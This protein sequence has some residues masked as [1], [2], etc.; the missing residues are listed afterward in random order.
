MRASIICGRVALATELFPHSMAAPLILGTIG[1]CGGERVELL[2]PWQGI[3]GKASLASHTLRAQLPSEPR[4]ARTGGGMH[5]TSLR[6]HAERKSQKKM[7]VCRL[8]AYVQS[9]LERPLPVPT[10]CVGPPC[11]GKSTYDIIRYLGGLATGP[12]EVSVPSY[13]LRCVSGVLDL[14]Q[15]EDV[16]VGHVIQ[17]HTTVSCAVILPF[18]A[19]QQHMQS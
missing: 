5:I 11:T 2:H 6:V 17:Q 12:V 9:L 14:I 16:A 13:S 18:H 10:C 7:Y 1:A 19:E 15:H 3:L 8:P 4:P